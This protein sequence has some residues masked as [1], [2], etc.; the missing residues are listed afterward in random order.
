MNIRRWGFIPSILL[1]T[2]FLLSCRDL[3]WLR[4]SVEKK[5]IGE[6]EG[7][8]DSGTWSFIFNKD[9]SWMFVNDNTVLPPTSDE[10]IVVDNVSWEVDDTQNPIHLDCI[11][12]IKYKES[13]ETKRVVLP[14][15]IRFVG[16]DKIQVRTIMEQPYDVDNT[17]S[18]PTMYMGKRP[19]GFETESDDQ[20][21]LTRQ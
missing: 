20:M 14:W 10:Q 2:L 7:T 16:Q 6:W 13:G 21:T 8:D 4:G 17:T 9:G 12:F 5:L 1:M 19:T 18:P 3:R 15:I 11:V